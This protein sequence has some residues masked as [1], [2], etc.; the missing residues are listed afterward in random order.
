M[1]KGLKWFS[2]ISGLIVLIFFLSFFVGEGLTD[3]LKGNGS[4]LIFFIPFCIP[5]VTGYFIAWFKPYIGGIIL[6]LG[7]LLLGSYF[8][9]FEDFSMAIVFAIPI[10]LIGLSFIASVNRELV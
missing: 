7:A 9:Y 3:I 5:A 2:R 10:L 8:V 4:E 6:I 1:H